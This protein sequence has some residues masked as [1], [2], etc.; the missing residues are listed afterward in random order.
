MAGKTMKRSALAA[1]ALQGLND[2]LHH[3]QGDDSAAIAHVPETVDLKSIRTAQG[4]S[5][6]VFASRYGFTAGAVRDWEQGRRQPERAARILLTIIEREPDVVNRAIAPKVTGG[7]VAGKPKS[8][9]HG[10][11]RAMA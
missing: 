8:A 2:A 9:E 1:R 3:A 5:Q 6:T 10:R 7:L 4:L 11:K